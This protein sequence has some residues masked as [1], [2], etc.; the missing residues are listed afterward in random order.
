M[1][2][3]APGEVPP[4]NRKGT[5]SNFEPLPSRT[6]GVDKI[7]VSFPVDAVAPDGDWANL[8]IKN[9]AD[10]PNVRRN[11]SIEL[12]KG[13]NVMVGVSDIAPTG[14]QWAKLEFNPSRVKDPDGWSAT[15]SAADS[16]DAVTLAIARAHSEGFFNP[17]INSARDARVKRLDLARDF[18]GVSDP[19][20]LIG[21]LIGVHRNHARQARVFYD[22]ERNG[23]QTL[24]VGGKRDQ[25]R[26]YD[27]AQE[28]GEGA[29]GV[30]RVEFLCRDWL[31]RY[32]NMRNVG[33]MTDDSIDEL[34]RDR[35]EWS[36]MGTGVASSLQIVIDSVKRLG[37]TPTKSRN[38]L[39]YLMQSAYGV[40]TKMSKSTAAE[41]RRLARQAGVSMALDGIDQ[42]DPVGVIVRL[43]LES[44]M[45][46][47]SV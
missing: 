15:A 2:Y 19:S 27:K 10:G 33:D 16:I 30:V 31:M 6:F 4:S 28:S 29:A 35:F 18:S 22:P 36:G 20:S 1:T 23:A 44:G 11:D 39:G 26:A 45:E 46:V 17:R 38:L 47:L 25:A 3:G 8:S 42:Q 9:T 21:G 24:T 43:D 41:Y 5:G 37:L 14:Q 13:V 40:P 32:G 7:S 34:G 12:C